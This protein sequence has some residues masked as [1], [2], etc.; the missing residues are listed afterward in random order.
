MNGLANLWS[1]LGER[2]GLIFDTD[3]G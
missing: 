3:L 2:L 1:V